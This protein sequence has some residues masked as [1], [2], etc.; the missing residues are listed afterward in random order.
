MFKTY[1]TPVDNVL[2]EIQQVFFIVI[3]KVC[4]NWFIFYDKLSD[5]NSFE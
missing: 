4:Y 3:L 5:I 1:G 2:F